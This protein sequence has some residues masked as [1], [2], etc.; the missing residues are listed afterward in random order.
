MSRTPSKLFGEKKLDESVKINGNKTP[1]KYKNA[2]EIANKNSGISK[3]AN[4]A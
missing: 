4:E 3:A 2:F 1:I